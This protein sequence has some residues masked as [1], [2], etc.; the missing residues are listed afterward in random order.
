MI[1]RIRR[2]F[3]GVT[4]I[5]VVLVLVALMGFL[6][7]L[8][9]TQVDQEADELLAFLAANG[10][11]FPEVLVYEE[12]VYDEASGELGSEPSTE[13]STEIVESAE[14]EKPA[15]EGKNAQDGPRRG[16]G[17]KMFEEDAAYPGDGTFEGASGELMAQ[18]EPVPGLGQGREMLRPTRLNFTEET[19]YETRFFSV[20]LG[21]DGTLVTADTTQIA[22]VTE[23]QAESLA[24]QLQ[25]DGVMEGYSGHYKF[26]AQ[27]VEE[28]VQYVFLDCTSDLNAAVK[29]LQISLLVSLCGIAVFFLLVLVFS[30]WVIRPMAASYDKQKQFITNAG[31]EIK[32]PLS[33]IGSCTEVLEMEQGEN[34]WTT[35]IQT[36]VERLGVL[37][38][39]LIALA[40]MDEAQAPRHEE[41]DLSVA[42]EEELEQFRVLAERR[43]LTLEL[44]IQPDIRYR[45]NESDLRQLAAILGD[46]AVNYTAP[47]GKIL[48]RL[49]R[50]G[51]KVMLV[52]ENPAQGFVPGSQ[53]QLFERF[54]RGDTSHNSETTGYGIGLSM[55]ESIAEAH[56]GK[57][58]AFSADGKSL[59]ITVRL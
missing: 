21:S 25:A 47:E 56:G 30:G 37:T 12:T 10:G 15:E 49:F 5:S 36:Q 29:F 20:T 8:N 43:G 44:E 27:D 9:F 42:V 48:F 26:L 18:T 17:G 24:R 46:N 6:N 13:M 3:I 4:M 23:A 35:A 32:T 1:G 59:T 53:P 33:V 54:Y 50:K 14:E 31:H 52:G 57:I 2:K 16:R 45:G 39:E 11:M 55:A 28:G 41:F 34:K 38:Q 22:A 58:S 7:F 19:P 51:R 40:R